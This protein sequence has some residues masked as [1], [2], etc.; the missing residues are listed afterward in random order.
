[1]L[2]AVLIGTHKAGL[3][4]MSIRQCWC[5]CIGVR[6]CE[7]YMWCVNVLQTLEAIQI[8]SY[9]PIRIRITLLRT[10]LNKPTLRFTI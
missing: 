3:W 6:E 7:H 5:I 4:L 10:I 8:N 1:M 9:L 2:S